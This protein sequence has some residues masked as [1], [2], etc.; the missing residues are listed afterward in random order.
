MQHQP[1]A[2][3]C[4][5]VEA[6]LE[7][8]RARLVLVQELRSALGRFGSM[9]N[10]EMSQVIHAR[11]RNRSALQDFVERHEGRRGRQ[12]ALRLV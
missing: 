12:L 4:R 2:A 8:G 3:D 11:V 7:F 6:G 1:A 5:L 10:S 9:T